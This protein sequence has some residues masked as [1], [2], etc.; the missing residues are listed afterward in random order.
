MNKL[1]SFQSHKDGFNICKS[2]DHINK[3]Q[4]PIL[5]M[6]AQKAFDKIQHSCLKKNLTKVGIKNISQHNKRHLW[7]SQYHNTEKMKVFPLNSGQRCLVSLL[8]INI[9][10][11]VLACHSKQTRKVIRIGKEK[12]KVIICRWH[13]TLH[14]KNLKTPHKNLEMNVAR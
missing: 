3:R 4:K 14:K 11:E 8:I 5:S 12:V 1:D 9:V 7:Q 6:D 10:L 13:D 2:I